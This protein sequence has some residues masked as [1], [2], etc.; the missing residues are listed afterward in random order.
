VQATRRVGADAI[1]R[2][3]ATRWLATKL[4]EKRFDS[5]LAGD[6]P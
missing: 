2:Q 3:M 6:H 5:G 4:R 1:A